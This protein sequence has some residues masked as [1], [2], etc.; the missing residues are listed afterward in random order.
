MKSQ[1]AKIKKKE[2]THV[3]ESLMAPMNSGRGSW[4]AEKLA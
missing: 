3:C 2:E 4:E 1:Q